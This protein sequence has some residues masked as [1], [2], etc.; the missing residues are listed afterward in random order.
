MFLL[1]QGHYVSAK[2]VH[3]QLAFLLEMLYQNPM[4]QHIYFQRNQVHW[5]LLSFRNVITFSKLNHPYICNFDRINNAND[6]V[7]IISKTSLRPWIPPKYPQL[8]FWKYSHRPCKDSKHN[9]YRPIFLC[10]YPKIINSV[11]AFLSFEIYYWF[12]LWGLAFQPE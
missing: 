7:S 6:P 11:L 1:F 8:I 3:R 12:L 2:F 10:S 5:W 4:L 9:L